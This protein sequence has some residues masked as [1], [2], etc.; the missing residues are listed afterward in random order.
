MCHTRWVG[1]TVRDLTDGER[2]WVRL[3]VDLAGEIA[4]GYDLGVEPGDQ[5]V[6]ATLDTAWVN[7]LQAHDRA[8]E[9]PNPYINAFGCALGDYLVGR[10]GLDWRVISDE[11]GTEMAIWGEPGDVRIFPPNLVAKRYAEGA[12]PFFVSV[13]SA[14]EERIGEMRA[15]WSAKPAS[16]V[17]RLFGRR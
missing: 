9:D 3:N 16:R 11:Y 13:A 12:G 6:P 2:R 8:N 7:W 14:L 17:G 4:K 10:L 1:D 15:A 5:L